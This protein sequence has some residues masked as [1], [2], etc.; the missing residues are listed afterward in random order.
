ML[1]IGTITPEPRHD[2][3]ACF[4]M[5]ADFAWQSQKLRAIVQPNCSR[6]CSRRDR[7]AF[8]FVPISALAQL[9]IGTE[10]PAFKINRQACFGIGSERGIASPG[11]GLSRTVFAGLELTRKPAFGIVGAPDESAEL[12]NLERKLPL[13][14]KRAKPRIAAVRLCR[15]DMRAKE[16]VQRIEDLCNTQI[17][18]IIYRRDEVP[19]EFAQQL[20]PIEL[21]VRD[22]VETVFQIGREVV[23]HVALEKRFEEGGDEP[24]FVLGIKPL[25]F[26]LYIFALAKKPHRA[27]IS[28]RAANTEAFH[29]A[30]ERR[31]GK[32]RRR[33][34]E[35]L[36]RFHVRVTKLFAL[37]QLWETASLVV[38]GIVT[39]F[40]IELQKAIEENN[41]A[42]RAHAIRLT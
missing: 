17:L 4:R 3:F 33:F 15:E 22:K 23:F 9:N 16:F 5:N 35:M 7:G 30:D 21:S 24:A 2:G 39:A 11:H 12:A 31:L 41:R 40:L 20:L 37:L 6:I 38:L 19:P 14:A 42:R 25:L 28:R 26:E 10:T 13:I 32:A 34:G 27:R 36:G 29:F 8:G 1:D 18:N